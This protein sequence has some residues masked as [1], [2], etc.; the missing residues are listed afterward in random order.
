MSEWCPVCGGKL[1]VLFRV[2]ERRVPGTVPEHYTRSQERPYATNDRWE[3]VVC[4]N[5]HEFKRRGSGLYGMA[6]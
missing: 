4:P 6:A 3:E 1:T 5:G 2:S